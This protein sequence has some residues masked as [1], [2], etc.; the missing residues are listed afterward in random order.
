MR[1]LIIT[2]YYHPVM[3]PNV[4]RWSALAEHWAA[5]G[6]EVHVLCS[7]RSPF[8][9]EEIIQGVRVHRAG[10]GSLQDWVFNWM[11]TP[12]RRAEPGGPVVQNSGIVR[13]I[14][15]RLLDLTWRQLYWP[16]G[17]CTWFFSG[18]KAAF[19]LHRQ[20]HFDRVISVALPFTA[21]LIA[22]ALKRKNPDLFWLMDIEDPFAFSKEF[23]VNNRFLYKRWNDRAEAKLLRLADAVSLTLK[24]ALDRYQSYFPE[25][26]FGDKMGVVPPLVNPDSPR[27][28]GPPAA[29]DTNP[30]GEGGV[31][32]I[33]LAYF[34]T[35][36]KNVRTPAPF[37]AF[38]E[39]FLN[40]FP[41]YRQKL[42]VDFFGEM[43]GWVMAEFDRY[44]A[45]KSI[46]RF[47]GLIPRDQVAR[48]IADTGFLINIGNTTDY[49]LPSKAAE[50]LCSGKPIINI[51][52]HPGDAFREFAGDYPLIWH[53]LPG[54]PE[55]EALSAFEKFLTTSTGRQ[56]PEP[57][58]QQWI[59]KYSVSAI[60]RLYWKLIRG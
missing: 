37:F 22:G 49:H 25:L 4:F 59:N 47:H 6:H 21:N 27:P 16:D 54:Q 10:H 42:Q 1:I 5:Q 43:P 14:L 46:L 13:R 26:E 15:E 60:S 2:V 56:I 34:G 52:L 19:R 53:Y 38:L 12:I 57:F 44:P 20:Y 8:P 17:A 18:K 3:T 32:R 33:K 29:G 48:E 31:K 11:K 39:Q 7:E 45:L 9:K 40:A 41:A 58:Q 51:M 36:Y 50:Y 28:L 23:R 55:K 35:F 24:N 30:T